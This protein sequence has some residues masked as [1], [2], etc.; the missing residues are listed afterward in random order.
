MEKVEKVQKEEKVEK[1][2]KV[3]EVQKEEGWKRVDYVDKE[4]RRTITDAKVVPLE[5]PT[6]TKRSDPRRGLEHAV[7]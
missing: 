4:R 2:E 3:E 7:Q 5:H 6:N 1:V